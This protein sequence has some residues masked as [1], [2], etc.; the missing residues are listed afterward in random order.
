MA[1]LAS[2]E[3]GPVPNGSCAM[4]SMY[5]ARRHRHSAAVGRRRC[6]THH[7]KRTSGPNAVSSTA[8]RSGNLTGSKRTSRERWRAPEGLITGQQRDIPINNLLIRHVPL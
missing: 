5:G 1:S 7:L 4:L 2:N 8:R 6:F 3:L